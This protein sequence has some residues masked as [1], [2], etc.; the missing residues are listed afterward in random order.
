M[1]KLIGVKTLSYNDT[2]LLR[3]PGLF[4]SAHSEEGALCETG[5]PDTPAFQ[6]GIVP[7]NVIPTSVE[8]GTMKNTRG[9]ADARSHD[10]LRQS[11]AERMQD[12]S[13][14]RASGGALSVDTLTALYERAITAESAADGLKLLHELQVHQVELDLLYEQLQTNEQEANEELE[15][16]KALY[17]FAPAAYLVVTNDGQIVEANQA[18]A[19]LFNDTSRALPGKALANLLAPGQELELKR[20]LRKPGEGVLNFHSI[21]TS[22]MDLSHSRRLAINVRHAVSGDGALLILAETD[23]RSDPS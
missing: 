20:M 9:Y 12:G 3:K 17:E 7:N 5:M 11:A 13:A 16:Y 15:Y 10:R 6:S 1:L 19:A 21:E 2:R 8:G 18:A 23:S 4:A 14:P 22:M